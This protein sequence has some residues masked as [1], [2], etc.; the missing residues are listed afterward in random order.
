MTAY[1]SE[2]PSDAQQATAAEQEQ[3]AEAT[4]AAEAAEE[5]LAVGEGEPSLSAEEAT[6]TTDA[7]GE[8]TTEAEGVGEEASEE[9]AEPLADGWTEVM[10]WSSMDLY[11]FAFTSGDGKDYIG[12]LGY[13]RNSLLNSSYYFTSADSNAEDAGVNYT[14]AFSRNGFGTSDIY[15]RGTADG[16]NFSLNMGSVEIENVMVKDRVPG[17]PML[18]AVGYA[19]FDANNYLEIRMTMIPFEDGTVVHQYEVV[20][21]SGYLLDARLVAEIDTMLVG[22]DRVPVYSQGTG[23]GLYIDASNSVSR[24]TF[25]IQQNGYGNAPIDYATL[26]WNSNWAAAFGSD[27]SMVNQMGAFHNPGDLLLSGV[28]SEVFFLWGPTLIDPGATTDF[29]YVVS[30]GAAV[31]ITPVPP[32]QEEPPVVPAPEEPPAIPETGDSATA[33]YV[34]ATLVGVSVVLMGAAIAMRRRSRGGHSA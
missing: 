17:F 7:E 11:Q 30:L 10:N 23:A 8:V 34:V 26:G 32:Q 4:E 1:A 2:V 18:R 27:F 31:P 9:E 15:L 22:N 3:A 33:L 14:Y 28:D 5:V 25:P 19:Y 13:S 20:N 16:Q 12:H 24:V 29:Q 6:E 21:N